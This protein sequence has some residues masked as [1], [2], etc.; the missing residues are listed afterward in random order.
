MERARR[1]YETYKNLIKEHEKEAKRLW[2]AEAEKVYGQD[3]RYAK[4]HGYEVSS[5]KK[6]MNYNETG[7][8]WF[9][10]STMPISQK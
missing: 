5:V 9:P 6:A 2:D 4:E 1:L 8:G 10:E 7:Y 3:L